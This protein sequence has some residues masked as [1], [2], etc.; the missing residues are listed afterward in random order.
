L[1]SSYFS[2]TDYCVDAGSVFEYY[3]SGAYE[4]SQQQS[5][6]TDFYGSSYCSAGDTVYKNF[7]DYSCAS[8]Q[9]GQST[10]PEYQYDCDM[11]DHNS[12]DYCIN[13]S[14]YRDVNNSYCSGGSCSMSTTQQLV[15]ACSYPYT[16]SGGQCI[17]QNS[18]TDTDGGNNPSV[19]GNAT[20][21]YSQQYYNNMDYCITSSVL[22]EYYCS[23]GL[24]YNSTMS[25]SGNYTGCTNGACY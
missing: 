2:N 19:R 4:Q 7:T 5:C 1:S 10:T 8:G 17:V 22:V 11:Y 18:C 20:G 25:C 12:S 13:S 23:V 6:G 16:C 3:C 24:K 14:I 15:Q 21:Y 9:C